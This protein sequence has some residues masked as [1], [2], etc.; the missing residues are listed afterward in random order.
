MGADEG[1][2]YKSSRQDKILQ[3]KMYD[4]KGN[5]GRRLIENLRFSPAI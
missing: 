1:T 5:S 3:R 4:T 2:A